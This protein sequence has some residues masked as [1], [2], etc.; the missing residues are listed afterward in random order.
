MRDAW[1]WVG[2]AVIGAVV[3]SGCLSLRTSE[4][5]EGGAGGAGGSGGAGGM[6]GVGGM[7]GTG[8][9][10]MS[11]SS[12]ASSTS[13]GGPL[14][15]SAADCTSAVICRVGTCVDSMCNEED[16]PYGA[17]MM[18]CSIT[19]ACDG[20]GACKLKNG[21]ACSSNAECLSNNCASGGNKSCAP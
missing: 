13:S 16:A 9:A 11:S 21:Q 8:G 19:S 18:D 6:G 5:G 3:M 1:A 7:G 10:T 14:C 17:E 12:S 2:C 20:A 15:T 4:G